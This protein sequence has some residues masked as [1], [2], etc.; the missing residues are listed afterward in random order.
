MSWFRKSLKPSLQGIAAFFRHEMHARIHAV[1][2]VFVLAAGVL[3]PL[4]ATEWLLVLLAISL[5]F[6]TEITNTVFEHLA[7]YVQPQY[8]PQIRRIKDLAAGAVLM[9][10]IYALLT[11]L[12]I[13]GP[14]LWQA[15]TAMF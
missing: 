14:W 15:L 11:G 7:D 13:F 8:H 2:A 10:A 3:L 6:I 12:V 9:A 1:I 4:T 5:V